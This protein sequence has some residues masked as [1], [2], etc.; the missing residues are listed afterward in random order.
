MERIITYKNA[1]SEALRTAMRTNENI[2][3][4]GEDLV[5]GTDYSNP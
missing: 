5:G 4:M 2:V 1:I 3:L